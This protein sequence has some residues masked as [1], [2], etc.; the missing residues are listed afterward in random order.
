MGSQIVPSIKFTILYLIL[1]PQ[2][3]LYPRNSLGPQLFMIKKFMSCG[4]RLESII[5]LSDSWSLGSPQPEETSVAFVGVTADFMAPARVYVLSGTSNQVYDPQADSWTTG[6]VIPTS[7]GDFAVAVVDD[8]IYVIGGLTISYKGRPQGAGGVVTYYATVERY[9]P[10]GYGS[11]PPAVSITS[12]ESAASYA[13]GVV[14][15]SFSLNK[16]ASWVGYSL[17]G[18]DNVTVAGNTTLTGLSAGL[19][20]VTVYA[21]DTNENVGASETIVFTVAPESFLSSTLVVVAVAVLV[22]VV[23]V[24]LFLYFR[25]HR[26]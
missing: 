5:L 15:L 19:H 7:R 14:A 16:P 11:V 10:I 8:L 24:G 17:D 9:T 26:G 25:K 4:G 20:N 13:S 6:A 23:C 22:G 21:K 1:G 12:F 2:K 3:L 18:K